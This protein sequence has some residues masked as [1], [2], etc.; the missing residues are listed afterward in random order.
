MAVLESEGPL[1]IIIVRW[2]LYS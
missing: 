2:K 1:T